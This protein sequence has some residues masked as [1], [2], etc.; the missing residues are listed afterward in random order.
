MRP[1]YE[2]LL[3]SLARHLGVSLETPWRD[4]SKRDRN[5]ILFGLG[6]EEVTFELPKLSR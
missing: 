5:A 4:L 2:R 1:Y 6:D 3:A